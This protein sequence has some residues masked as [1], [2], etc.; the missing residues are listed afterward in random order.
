VQIHRKNQV[1]AQ[2]KVKNNY[3][4]STT[5]LF[6]AL[7]WMTYNICSKT[8]YTNTHKKKLNYKTPEIDW[9]FKLWNAVKNVLLAI[10]R[11]QFDRILR[12]IHSECW[13]A[14]SWVTFVVANGSTQRTNRTKRIAVNQWLR[15]RCRVDDDDDDDI[16][17]CSFETP[18]ISPWTANAQEYHPAGHT[19]CT[20]CLNIGHSAYTGHSG[21][22]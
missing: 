22:Y 11:L 7:W 20:Q 5:L 4:H 12:E 3:L 16:D 9:K 2:Y 19:H 18:V 15:S 6:A 13:Q 21:S 14:S 17:D 1:I 10:M 8:D